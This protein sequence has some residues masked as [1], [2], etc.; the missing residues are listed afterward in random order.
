M[1]LVWCRRSELA[2][3]AFVSWTMRC[4]FHKNTCF[5]F[6]WTIPEQT[7]AYASMKLLLVRNE[8][9]STH[10]LNSNL[11]NVVILFLFYKSSKV[12]RILLQYTSTY[13]ILYHQSRWKHNALEQSSMSSIKKRW[14][15]I[16]MN[17]SEQT[18]D[19]CLKEMISKDEEW[20]ILH[21]IK[22]KSFQIST[23]CQ[24]LWNASK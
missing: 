5:H 1:V 11:S 17:K 3:F 2:E 24:V 4:E 19:M 10:F 15:S 18:L 8:G 23:L 14:Y 20:R 13:I 9:S 16:F 21:F 12:T 6:T 7:L 22:Y